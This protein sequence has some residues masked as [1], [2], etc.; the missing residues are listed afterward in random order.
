[1]G[2]T[3]FLESSAGQS[4]L[5]F[6]Q[7]LLFGMMVYI[8]AAEFIRTKDKSLVYK[9][10]AAGSI[11][12]ISCSTA[13][14]YILDAFY[15]VTIT[16]KYFPLIFNGLFAF[17]VLSLAR[18]FTYEFVSNRE[19]FQKFINTGMFLS[20]IMYIVMQTYWLMN[21]QPGMQFW[22]SRLQLMFSLF[23][24]CML[25]FSI[26]YI[27]RFRKSYKFRLVTAFSSI[28]VVQLINIYGS[29]AHYIPPSLV[30]I[31][32][33]AP[34]LVPVMFTSVVFKELIGRVVLLVE[35]I[36]IT[37]EYQKE[38]VFELINIGAELSSMSDNLV[39]TALDG[40]AK[41]SFVVETIR[42]QINDSDSLSEI[43]LT[44][45][46]RLKSL[47]FKSIEDSI[48]KLID[49]ASVSEIKNSVNNEKLLNDILPELVKTSKQIADASIN[50]GRLK[51]LL[52]AVSS[53]LDGIDDISDRTNI[54]SLNASIEAA[55]A[56]A[57]GRGFAVVAEEIG[58]LA[59]SSLTGS[60]EVRKNISGIISLFRVYEEKAVSAVTDL[61]L[62]VEKLGAVNTGTAASGRV[63]IDPAVTEGIKTGIEIYNSVVVDIVSKV[64]NVDVITTRGRVLAGEMK[65]KI[66]E[67]I[68]NIE[69][70][71]GISDMIND[72][73]AKLN[74]K[75]NIIIEQTG[76]LEKLTS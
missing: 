70:I 18:A 67:H 32:A 51:E 36:R 9:L 60:K 75:I 40:W 68:S 5:Y 22:S 26:Y 44:S 24:I 17:V 2:L 50:A 61:N 59:E 10:M 52:P 16:Q 48:N 63:E 41:L 66:S 30:I 65:T 4:A 47:N 19:K 1:M 56:G 72:L 69:S 15:N 34:M 57:Q 42:E 62:L 39:K 46:E 31:K 35:Q 37:F 21:F 33:A 28:A 64:D 58:R 43:T 7:T 14:I 27:V 55:R 54:L 13:L 11:T 73:V 49:A 23:F 6:S 45:S 12:A 8:L 71:A 74:N 3:L 25:A 53:A 29:L 38:L 76:E 20:G